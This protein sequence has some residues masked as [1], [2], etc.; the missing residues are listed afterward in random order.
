MLMDRLYVILT[1]ELLI[2]YCNGS[3]D[4]VSILA[5]E[6]GV[7]GDGIPYGGLFSRV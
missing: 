7:H 3:M 6:D 5:E 2:I 1:S 4:T